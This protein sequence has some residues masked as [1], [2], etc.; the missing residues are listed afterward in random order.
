LSTAPNNLPV[1]LTSFVGRDKEI[2]K[3]KR[4][5]TTTRLLT[6]TGVGGTGK[7]RLSLRVAADVVNQVPDGVWFVDLAPLSDP[8][9][10]PQVVASSLGVREEP[11]RPIIATLTEY[12]CDKQVLLILDNCE[13]L[14]EA[15]AHF[16]DGILHSAPNMKI[17][18]TSREA[19]GI[20]G[21]ATYPVPT[22]PVPPE[23]A[24]LAE[25]SQFDA[26]R[27]FVERAAAAHAGFALTEANGPAVVQICQ[28]L[29]G[30]PLALE[31]AAVRVKV[32]SPEQ[33]VVRLDDR[34]RLLRG[35]SRTALP[36][37]Q[38]L[39]ALIDW[40][41][42]LLPENERILLR[43]LSV[44][45]GGW[46]FNAAEAVCAGEGLEIVDVLDLL[47]HLIEKSLVMV[48]SDDGELRYR[49]LETIRQ[50]AREKLV[51]S[52]EA[53]RVRDAHLH[54]F[55]R[56]VDDAAPKLFSAERRPWLHRLTVELD[57][58]RAALAYCQA[59]PSNA[60]LGLR[61]AGLSYWFWYFG[62]LWTERSRSIESL[63]AQTS[64]KPPTAARGTALWCAGGLALIRGD[65]AGAR[66]QLEKSIAI[67]RELQ[68]KRGLA[69][70]LRQLGLAA[71]D[72]NDNAVALS[73]L[74]EIVALF[75]ELDDSWDLA[76]SL[77]SLGRA[78][79]NLGGFAAALSLLEES[80]T[81][82]RS[83]GDTW[84]M[85]IAFSNLALAVLRQGDYGRA[86]ALYQE[87]LGL[88]WKSDE[89]FFTTRTLD[90]LARLAFLQ[91][92]NEHAAHLFGFAE[93]LRE[94]IGAVIAPADQGAHDDAVAAVRGQ[95]N[96]VSFHA[97]WA[98]G[99][100]MSLAQ[101]LEYAQSISSLTT[102]PV[103]FHNDPGST[104][105]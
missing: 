8:A 22:L 25:L 66:V 88:L 50:Y 13:H 90:E 103:R 53:E 96:E 44:F 97:A 81:I 80:L 101:A 76:L 98:A 7:T 57:N 9:L 29:D 3:I 87:S 102:K 47:T 89:E 49:M 27:L 67:L 78:L 64:T 6:L 60:E 70:A 75:R 36:R 24:S 95:M 41:Y 33:I 92:D 91:G 62:R 34:F 39:Q 68:D 40:S 63:L 2:A 73:T 28:R 18:A 11:M 82:S 14:I 52:G 71:R 21:E 16:T 15:C 19:L 65:F 48:E 43:R 38:T 94:Q 12:V 42:S 72:S 85:G 69:N 1:Q 105:T 30:I 37:Q 86:A 99:R 55:S 93:V 20:G 83:L 61:L 23:R 51:E 26:V 46:S 56:L 4:L 59:S 10:V 104:H 31:L 54:F 77:V 45:A 32:F 100:A 74:E 5:L 79:V 84:A 35:G 17:L 58:L